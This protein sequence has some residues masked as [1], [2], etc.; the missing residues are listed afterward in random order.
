MS[1]SPRLL[2]AAR[3]ALGLPALIRRPWDTR[4]LADALRS[5]ERYHQPVRS[6]T[7][8]EWR[9]RELATARSVW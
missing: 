4:A 2:G 6:A 1:G 8:V 5:A 3:T 9:P 7:T